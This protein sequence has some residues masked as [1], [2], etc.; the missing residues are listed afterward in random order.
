ML[1]FTHIMP[2]M[3]SDPGS[4]ED[5]EALKAAPEDLYAGHA[6]VLAG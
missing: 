2:R 4:G 6:V 3:S 1:R 5:L